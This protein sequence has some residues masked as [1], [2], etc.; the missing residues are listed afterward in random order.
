M[1]HAEVLQC[2]ATE[3]VQQVLKKIKQSDK[4]VHA[5]LHINE[6]A[7]EQA[8]RVDAK[9]KKG[10]LAGL[11]V[12]VKA[13]ISVKGM[14][15]SCASRTLENYNGLFDADAVRKIKE[16]DGIIIGITN[17]DEF[18]CGSSGESSAFGA[19]KNPRA[20][21]RIPGGSSSGSAAAVAAGFCDVA[22]GTDTGGSVRN[23][24]SHCG[25]VGVKPSYGRVSRYGLVD[26]AMSLDTI[27]TMSNTVQQ[28][29]LLLQS[30]AGKSKYDARSSEKEV[31]QYTRV[32]QKKLTI[33]ICEELK[34]LCTDSRIYERMQEAANDLA[35]MTGGKVEKVKLKHLALAVQTYYPLVF[36]EFFSATR[37]I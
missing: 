12:A 27:G 24:A 15:I 22:L 29:A 14:P 8:E 13:N 34:D 33:G 4:E 31:E 20:E 21:G 19:T 16:A 5:M 30:I 6:Q 28:S 3:R 35:K 2:S 17:C 25:I 36:V 23:P 26:L 11:T 7:A 1:E 32:P 37:K 9:K 18:G 10:A